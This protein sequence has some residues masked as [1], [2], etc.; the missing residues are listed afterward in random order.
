MLTEAI[1]FVRVFL[2]GSG[3]VWPQQILFYINYLTSTFDMENFNFK[4][5]SCWCIW[6]MPYKIVHIGLLQK[7]LVHITNDI[8]NNVHVYWNVF[9]SYTQKYSLQMVSIKL[10]STWITIPHNLL[11]SLLTIVLFCEFLF[12][13]CV[14]TS[15]S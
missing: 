9:I 1:R 5:M 7:T 3:V 12:L 4:Y 11:K 6:C 10:Y 14:C 8:N 2:L 15:L 13:H